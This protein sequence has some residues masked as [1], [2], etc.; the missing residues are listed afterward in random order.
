MLERFLIFMAITTSAI[1]FFRLAQRVLLR[2]RATQGLGF[3]GFEPG[4]P[5]I[6]YFTAPGCIPCI[7]IQKPALEA[8]TEQYG[9]SIQIFEFDAVAEPQMATKWGV[10]GVPT[11]FIIDSFGRPRKI[12]NRATTSDR[13]IAQL[14]KVAE[15]PRKGI[16]MEKQQLNIAE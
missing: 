5:A 6:L 12:N 1:L 16:Q 14:E 10:L 3:E 8:I 9:E 13:L 11:T 7:T 2:R 4:R 15:L